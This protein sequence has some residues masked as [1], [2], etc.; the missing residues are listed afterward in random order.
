M[1]SSFFII[2]DFHFF[3]SDTQILKAA[4]VTMVIKIT[5]FTILTVLLFAVSTIALDPVILPGS[6]VLITTADNRLPES[7][8]TQTFDVSTID[9]SRSQI[10]SRSHPI[11]L[12]SLDKTT[13]RPCRKF[14]KM[15]MSPAKIFYGNDMILSDKTTSVDVKAIS[16]RVPTKWMEF[17]HKYGHRHHQDKDEKLETK[18]EFDGERQNGMTAPHKEKKSEH[19]GGFMRRVRKF[20]KHT[21]N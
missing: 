17:K 20:L 2:Y 15:F 11:K 4:L 16:D 10:S 6:D 12:H 13:R 9:P 3:L 19:K 7:E 14:K 1:Y 18:N 8:N 21:F 5:T